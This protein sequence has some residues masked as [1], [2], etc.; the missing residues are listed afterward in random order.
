MCGLCHHVRNCSSDDDE[1]QTQNTEIRTGP[2]DIYKC[3]HEGL[4]FS[5]EELC[6]IELV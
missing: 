3:D 6:R 1:A 2:T 4:L 5:P